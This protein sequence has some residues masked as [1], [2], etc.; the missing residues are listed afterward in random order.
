M[1][2]LRRGLAVTAAIALGAAA[3]QVP[4]SGAGA[5]EGPGPKSTAKGQVDDRPGPLTKKQRAL[6]QA[7]LEKVIRGQAKVQ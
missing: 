6:K 4:S 1:R 3:L 2:K 7:A 5:A